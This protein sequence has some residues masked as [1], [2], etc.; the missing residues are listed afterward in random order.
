MN[1]ESTFSLEGHPY[2]ELNKLLKLMAVAQ[3][4]GEAKMM[5]RDGIVNVNKEVESRL[6]RKLVIGDQVNINEEVLISITE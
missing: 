3:S 6:R 1:Q 4:G 5:I 2:I